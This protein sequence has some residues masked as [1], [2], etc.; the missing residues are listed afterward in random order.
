VSLEVI[1]LQSGIGHPAP[2]VANVSHNF[3]LMPARKPLPF[4]SPVDPYAIRFENRLS[5]SEILLLLKYNTQYLW[6]IIVV[7]ECDL[8]AAIWRSLCRNRRWD[9]SLLLVCKPSARSWS[10]NV[11]RLTQRLWRDFR[12]RH[13]MRMVKRSAQRR[14]ESWKVSVPGNRIFWFYIP[15]TATWPTPS[16]QPPGPT[17]PSTV[18]FLYSIFPE[19]PT[20]D[21]LI[22]Q[23]LRTLIMSSNCFGLYRKRSCGIALLC[24]YLKDIRSSATNVMC[25][26]RG[27]KPRVLNF[28]GDQSLNGTSC[29]TASAFF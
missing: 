13:G 25:L 23:S 12:I 26:Q 8:D 5:T 16:P 7:L 19:A 29:Y 6:G 9:P 14:P 22:N 11:Q 28:T 2:C 21:T 1:R 18:I 20:K 4:L 15:P 10:I 17:L 24:G 3:V 27:V